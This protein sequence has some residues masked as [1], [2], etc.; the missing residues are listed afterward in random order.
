M[1]IGGPNFWTPGPVYS[2]QVRVRVNSRGFEY[3]F[4]NQEWAKLAIAFL[5][6]TN[7]EQCK[8]LPCLSQSNQSKR[9]VDRS[10]WGLFTNPIR[11]FFGWPSE[12]SVSI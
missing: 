6:R 5:T 9:K 2:S 1:F 11:S 8:Q 7:M 10:C 3:V 12:R 4:E